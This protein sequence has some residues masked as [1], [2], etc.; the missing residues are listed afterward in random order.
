MSYTPN[1]IDCIIEYKSSRF[2]KL[3]TTY[4]GIKMW[5][6]DLVETNQTNVQSNLKK[7]LSG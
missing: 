5:S 7:V 2:D 6:I 1:T 3:S 4:I